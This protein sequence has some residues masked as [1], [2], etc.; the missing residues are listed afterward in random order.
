MF[1]LSRV[2]EE[3][4]KSRNNVESVVTGIST[5]AIM[6]ASPALIMIAVLSTR[7]SCASCSCR[8]R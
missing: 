6:I 7:R 5:T 1:L 2:R 8:R 3:F 4:L